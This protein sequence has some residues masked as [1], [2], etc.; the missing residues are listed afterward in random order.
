LDEVV[1]YR[2][3]YAFWDVEAIEVDSIW[4]S[5]LMQC[6]CAYYHSRRQGEYVTCHPMHADDS[7]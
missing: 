7:D 4:G 6:Q 1:W 5:H 3:S 2:N